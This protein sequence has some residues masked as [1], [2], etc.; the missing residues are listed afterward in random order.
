M[1][2]SVLNYKLDWFIRSGK[3]FIGSLVGLMCKELNETPANIS[4]KNI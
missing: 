3:R 4:L 2:N 1:A